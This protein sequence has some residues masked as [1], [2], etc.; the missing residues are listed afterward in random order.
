MSDKKLKL[1]DMHQEKGASIWLSTLPLKDEGYCLN[2]QEFSDLVKLRYGWPSS[3]LPTQC[4]CG[5]QCDVQNSLSCK[6]G[7]FATLR[8]NHI[9]NVTAELLSQVTKHLKIEPV[10][11]SLT[12]KTF[13]QRT[14]NTSDAARLDISARGFWTKYQM[15]FF[16]VKI[17]DPNAKKD[18][19]QSLQRCYNNNEKEN[20]RPYNMIVL[21]VENGSFTPLAFSIN[22]RMGREASKC[23]S[24]IAEM[25]SEKRDEP[26]SLTMSWIRGKL[27][28]SLMRLIITCIRGSRTFKP[29]EEKQCT[30]E[31]GSYSETRSKTKELL[32]I[33][34]YI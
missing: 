17:F 2:K 7:G 20:K 26:Y 15:A 4:I 23:Y 22:G 11:Q 9:K 10:L 18:S 24:R 13:E 32:C 3:R 21:Q 30:S 14:A 29:N 27:S 16:D 34:C 8:H 1:N 6:K 25:L 33:N 12:G 31:I 5:A 19:A 28:F